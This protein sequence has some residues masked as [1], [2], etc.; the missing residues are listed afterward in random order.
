MQSGTMLGVA[1]IVER[2][3]CAKRGEMDERGASCMRGQSE[4]GVVQD[5]EEISLAGISLRSI[6]W[7]TCL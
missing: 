6:V 1:L 7:S 5:G 2:L 4:S 3:N